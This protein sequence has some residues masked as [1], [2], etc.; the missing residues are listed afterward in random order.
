MAPRPPEPF[1]PCDHQRPHWFLVKAPGRP[2]DMMYVYAMNEDMHDVVAG[3]K[4]PLNVMTA[5]SALDFLRYAVF[6]WYRQ[7]ERTAR[8][9][10][11]MPPPQVFDGRDGPTEK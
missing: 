6:Q 11:G 4:D 10:E 5:E 1:A 3:D 9:E 8:E 2:L 7:Y